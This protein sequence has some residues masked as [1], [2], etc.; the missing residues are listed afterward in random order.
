MKF[1]KKYLLSLILAA[2]S[3]TAPLSVTSCF[4]FRTKPTVA[5]YVVDESEPSYDG[6][7]QNSGLIDYIEGKGFLITPHAAQRYLA[8]VKEYGND[9]A[10]PLVGSEGL[11][12]DPDSS[13][14]ILDSQHMVEFVAMSQKKKAGIPPLNGNRE[15][16]E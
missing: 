12:E 10:P 5:E 3:V 7:E 15:T 4:M 2:V 13:N 8:L 9:Y 14:Y 11:S 1:A 6:N 16:N